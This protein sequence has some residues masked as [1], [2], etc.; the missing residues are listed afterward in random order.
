M[1]G[2]FGNL[3]GRQVGVNVFGQLLALFTELINFFGNI[4]G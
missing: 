3:P 1:T 4:N 2:N